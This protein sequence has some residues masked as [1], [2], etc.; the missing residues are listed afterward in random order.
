ML[1]QMYNEMLNTATQMDEADCPPN[2]RTRYTPEVL[3][4]TKEAMDF[5]HERAEALH[6]DSTVIANR[7]TLTAFIDTPED[8]TN[9]L[10]N[11]W[12]REVIG[13][14]IRDKFAV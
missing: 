14:A 2:P 13:R 4:A 1:T 11:G 3:E 8:D 10:A 12:R 7:A 6:V 9:P 5:L